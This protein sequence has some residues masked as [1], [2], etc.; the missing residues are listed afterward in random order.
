MCILTDGRSDTMARTLAQQEATLAEHIREQG[1]H[2]TPADL[3]DNY[4]SIVRADL[5]AG[6]QRITLGVP[7]GTEVDMSAELARHLLA[8][9]R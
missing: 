2:T 5:A 9:G 4:R 8:G 3:V 6:L 1:S 7:C